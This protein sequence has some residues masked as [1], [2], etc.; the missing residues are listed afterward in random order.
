MLGCL[1]GLTYHANRAVLDKLKVVEFKEN[2][3]IHFNFIDTVLYC[4]GKIRKTSHC[5]IDGLSSSEMP[6]ATS[7]IAF[8]KGIPQVWIV[9]CVV[10]A[11]RKVSYGIKI[12]YFKRWEVCL[13]KVNQWYKKHCLEYFFQPTM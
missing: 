13:Y 2:N 3:L 1:L 8:F 5:K 11:E 12:L 4:K 10:T 9:W 7:V 6:C